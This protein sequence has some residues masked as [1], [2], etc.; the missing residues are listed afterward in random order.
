MAENEWYWTSGACGFA[1]VDGSAWGWPDRSGLEGCSAE[2]GNRG[3]DDDDDD[4]DGDGDV[5][6]VE[7]YLTQVAY[8][9]SLSS[10]R[11]HV[12]KGCLGCESCGD[13]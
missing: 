10:G 7:A 2:D 1:M 11:T 4:D 5:L 9:V 8:V 3:D 6:Y 13:T 12:K